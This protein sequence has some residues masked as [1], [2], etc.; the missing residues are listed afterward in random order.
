MLSANSLF[1]CPPGLSFIILRWYLPCVETFGIDRRNAATSDGTRENE[2][3]RL[4]STARKRLRH[5]DCQGSLSRVSFSSR[6][7]RNRIACREIFVCNRDSPGFLYLFI[8]FLLCLLREAGNL[9]LCGMN[10]N[11]KDERNSWNRSA[12]FRSANSFPIA[13]T[14]TRIP[15]SFARKL[16]CEG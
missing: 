4:I 14:R 8:F 10:S 7:R 2:A 15:F 16:W 5:R 12:A 9:V 13:S 1:L 3:D 11:K 6:G